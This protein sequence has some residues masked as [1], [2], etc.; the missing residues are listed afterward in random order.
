M[1]LTKILFITLALTLLELSLN[2]SSDRSQAKYAAATNELKVQVGYKEI[3][4]EFEEE[5]IDKVLER[6]YDVRFKFKNMFTDLSLESPMLKENSFRSGIPFQAKNPNK[7]AVN[8]LSEIFLEL[9]N[10]ENVEFIPFVQLT[11]GCTFEI[12]NMPLKISC[13]VHTR[14]GPEFFE[15]EFKDVVDTEVL[16]LLNQINKLKNL[17][18]TEIS[19][20]VNGVLDAINRLKIKQAQLE[21]IN[22]GQIDFR[23]KNQAIIDRIK[24]LLDK[25]RKIDDSLVEE[26]KKF[27]T[28]SGNEEVIRKQITDIREQISTAQNKIINLNKQIQLEKTT[29]VLGEKIK[30]MENNLQFALKTCKYW[31]QGGVYHRI[32]DDPEAIELDKLISNQPNIA[33]FIQVVDEKFSPQ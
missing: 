4:Q 19:K 8:N 13:T 24:E 31:I 3:L 33:R 1:K 7:F 30:L 2:Y 14:K 26:K 6:N 5:F 21:E 27:V 10:Y 9:K 20:T 29:L 23:I 32:I 25:N 15:F 22:K 16:A 28:L 17:R 11:K 12:V 18:E